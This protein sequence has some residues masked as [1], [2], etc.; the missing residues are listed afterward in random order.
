VFAYPFNNKWV[1][2]DTWLPGLG[3]LL[4]WFAILGMIGWL[5]SRDGRL[6][7]CVLLGSM[8]P[9]S[10]TWTVRGGAEWRF[11]L[12]AY[13]FYLVAAFWFVERLMG[14]ALQLRR[15][16]TLR[17]TAGQALGMATIVVA[18]ICWTFL[19]PYIVMHE[20]LAEGDA[21]MI[22]AGERDRFLLAQGWSDLVVTHNVTTRF[23]TEPAASIRLPLPQTRPYKLFLRIDPLHYP[24]APTQRVHISLNGE[25]VSVLDLAWNPERVGEY[26]FML[27]AASVRRGPNMLTLRAETMVPISRAGTAFPEVPRDRDVGLR[28]WYMLVVPS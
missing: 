17:K 3:R 25:A 23:S 27:P 12:F 20:S 1:G 16:L 4:S 7:S 26:S 6:L 15:G 8:I 11:T 9:F 10:A 28:L 21:A 13:S 22:R 14:R 19:M 18:G 5:W 2:I 24:E